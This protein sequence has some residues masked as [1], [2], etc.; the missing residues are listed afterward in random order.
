MITTSAHIPSPAS[1]P[2]GQRSQAPSQHRRPQRVLLQGFASDERESIS[3]R[4][5]LAAV[6]VSAFRSG[7]D[8]VVVPNNCP[9]DQRH[10]AAANGHPVW[11]LNQLLAGTPVS[12]AQPAW[13]LVDQTHMRILDLTLPITAPSSHTPSA[14]RFHL[15][16]GDTA[17]LTTIHQVMLAVAMD[18]PCLLQGPTAAAKTTAVLWSAHLLGRPVLRLNCSGHSDTGELIGRFLPQSGSGHWQ[19]HEGAV[20]QA[21]RRGQWLLLDEVNLAA[22]DVIERLNPVLERP[23]SLVISEN[24]GALIGPGGA[25]VHTD[26]RCFGTMNPA[27]YAGRNRLSPAFLDR[28]LAQTSVP[29]PDS[30]AYRQLL[31]F[32]AT[33]EQPDILLPGVGFFHVPHSSPPFPCLQAVTDDLSQVAAMHHHLM[34]STTDQDLDD[35]PTIT[36]RL[37]LA[38]VQRFA[39][40]CTN[41][42]DP[43][44]SL[45]RAIEEVYVRRMP[46]AAMQEGLRKALRLQGLDLA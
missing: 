38:L 39:G 23:S 13:E 42:G 15:C 32:W 1:S 35:H 43:Q 4:L 6:E 8:A 21:M 11:E 36:R 17:T 5:R 28:W 41:G 16:C 29:D 37:L 19:F 18:W 44:R 20:P 30:L 10:Q 33:G 45:R 34:L 27:A 2:A 12:T 14:S 9:D 25:V 46:N 7:V 3:D 24:D 40:L 22:A 26:F 31:H